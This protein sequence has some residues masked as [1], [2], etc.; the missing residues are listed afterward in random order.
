MNKGIRRL[1]NQ[2]HTQNRDGMHIGIVVIDFNAHTMVYA[3]AKSPLIYFQNQQIMEIKGERTSIGGIL[4]NRHQYRNFE[5]HTIYLPSLNGQPQN[6]TMLYLFTDGYTDQFGGKEG[7]RFSK[8]RMR[9]LLYEIHQL[10]LQEQKK[11]LEQ[12]LVNWMRANS[13]RQIDDI[14]VVG[15]KI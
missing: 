4:D 2:Q 11:I 12:N 8:I 13:G 10:P 6:K 7:R 15:I 3:G 9:E 1:L 14:L 5:N